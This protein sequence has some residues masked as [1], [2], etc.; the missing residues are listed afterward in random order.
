MNGAAQGAY[1][2][3]TITNATT[4][5]ATLSIDPAAT[6]GAR[7]VTVQTPGSA[8]QIITVNNG[9]TVQ[10]TVPTAP[11][12]VTVSP[13][14]NTAGVPINTSFTV[15]FSG[16]IN[17]STVAPTNAYLSPNQYGCSPTNAI[18]FTENVDAS[19]R[20]LTLTPSAVL[21]VG[22]SYYFCINYNSTPYIKDPSG[23]VVS[24]T[25]FLFT[26]GFATSN[27]GPTY[28]TGS[29]A[30]GDTGV[31][32]N[33]TPV[34]GFD[35]AF[36]P[37]T[38]LSG[39]NIYQGS[40]QV[41]GVWS[42][43]SL[44][45]E[46][47]FTPAG[48]FAA[49]TTYTI[50]LSAALTDPAG[51]PLVNP[52]TIS[53]T[54]GAGADNTAA[55]LVS[56]TPISNST[57]GENPVI[58]LVFSKA[59]NPLTMTQGQ[60]YLYHNVTGIAV[61]G[62]TVTAS[63]DRRT[64]TMTL[65]GPLDPN[66]QYYWYYGPAYDQAQN[67]VG[68]NSIAFYTGASVDTT[69]PT[70]TAV[71]PPNGF[72]GIAVNAPIEILLSETIDPTTVNTTSLTLNP[73]MAGTVALSSSGSA[74]TFT[75][76]ANLTANHSYTVNA[77]GFADQNG[78]LV[79]PFSSSFTTS[80][81]PSSDTAQ[82]TITM[83]PTAGATG[84]ATN[85]V[86]VFTFSKPFDPVTV[87]NGG[88]IRL[89]D[90]T[91]S[92]YI[93]GALTFNAS[94][95]SVTFTPSAALEPNHQYCG[96][97]G[98]PYNGYIYD[99]AGNT[100]NYV[101]SQC[102]TTAAG[103]DT[104]PPTV[105]TV[106][107]LN[108]AARIGPNNPVTVTFSKPMNPTTLTN[109]NVALYVG[110]NVY[111]RSFSTSFDNT[112]LTFNSGNLPYS[113][114]FTVVVT[115]N[116]TDLA[117]NH[118]AG[119]FISTFTTI[120]QPTTTVPTVT[121]TR[122]VSGATGVPANASITWFI[123]EPLKTSTVPGAVQVSQNGVLLTGSITYASNNQVVI[124]T[125]AANF[126]A[127][128][129]I[130]AFFTSA[131]TDTSGN[132]LTNYQFSFTVAQALTS[133]NP[134][135]LSTSP[136]QYSS[137]SFQNSII[138]VQFSKPLNPAMV[139]SA[140][141][142]VNNCNSTAITGSL[143]LLAG[144]TVV[145]F[146]PATPLPASC[147]YADVYATSSLQDTSSLPFA[148]TSWRFY[149]T[150][151]RDTA[152]P[153]VSTIAPTANSTA[154]GTN[155]TI[156]IQFSEALDQI[157]VNT[158]TLTLTGNSV[159]IPW[160]ATFD[161]TGT[162]LTITPQAS[163]PASTPITVAL[164]SGVNDLAGNALPA[165]S[166]VFTT[167]SAPDF[168]QP[169]VISS[170]VVNG[171]TGVPVTSVF[172]VTYSKPIDTRT[173]VSAGGVITLSD[174]QTGA[175]PPITLSFSSDGTQATIQ[176]QSLLGVNRSYSLYVCNVQDLDGNGMS[177]C[178]GISFTTALVAPTGGPA[179]T[180][181]L[182]PNGFRI[183]TNVKPQIQ[184]DRPVDLT[185]LSGVT[186]LQ[187]S[188]PVS[189][190]IA[191]SV[192]NT[193]L[194][195][196]PNALLV[197]N[198]P[199][200]LTI[201]GV[202][203]AAGNQ[204]SGTVT[205]NFTTGP[206]IDL[207]TPVVTALTPPSGAITGTN[208]V[209]RLTFDEPINP[210]ASN[211][212]WSLYNSVTNVQ[213]PG[214][215]ISASS[216]LLSESIVWPGTLDPNTQYCW[217]AYY[218]YD[219]AG[220]NTYTGGFCFTTSSRPVTSAPTV[221]S[222]TPPNGQA[223]VPI[224]ALIQ[225][226]LSSLIDATSVSTTSL[227]LSPSA[228]ATS[229]VSLAPSGQTITLS[230][231]TGTLTPNTSYTL[232]AAG[233]KDLNGNMVMP[234]S[235]TFTTS[236]VND[237][238][239]GTITLSSP[240]P[241]ATGV[242][243]TSA[244]T[245]TL[246]KVLD[247]N[248]VLPGAFLVYANNNSNQQIPGTISIGG[249]G[250]T[251]T[252]TPVGPMPPSTPISVYVGYNSSLY[253]LAGNT[254]ND[255]YNAGFTTASTADT[256]PPAILSVTP[257]NG[258][259]NVGPNAVV[260][261]IFSKALNYNTLNA[262]NFILYNG[263]TNLGAS[264]SRSADNRTV[265]LTATLPYSSTIN[266]AVNTTVQDLAGNFLASPFS[267]SFTVEPQPLTSTA[268]VTQMRPSNGA[269]GVLLNDTITLYFTSPLSAATVPAAFYVS[270]NGVLL[271]GSV[272]VS[273]DG[274]SAVWTG[275]GFSN[276][277][278]IQVFFT[279]AADTSGN[280]VSSYSAS[281]TAAVAA[282]T[283]T[284]LV[285]A[286]PSQYGSGN[287]LNS[288]VDLQFSHGI[289]PSS[290]NS[291]TFY[292][293][294][295]ASGSPIAGTITQYQNNAVL[296]FTPGAALQPNTYYYVYYTAGL[297]DVNGVALAAGN[298]YFYTGTATNGT[299]PAISSAAP[300]SGAS[301]VGDNATI[302]FSFNEPMDTLSISSAAGG[303]TVTLTSGSTPIPFSL[304]F[305]GSTYTTVTLTPYAPLPDNA[306]LVL[307]LMNGITDPA[308]H[309]ISTQS[310]SFHT[311]VGADFSAPY[312]AY[313]SIDSSTPAVPVNSTFTLI[314]NK[315][316]DRN[317]VNTSSYSYYGI[318]DYTVGLTV[319]TTVSVSADGQTVTYV[320]VANLAPSHSFG[321]W[322]QYATDLN[323]NAQTNFAVNFTTSAG[324]VTTPPAVITTNPPAGASGVPLNVL[325][326]AQFSEAVSGAS[327]SQISLTSGGSSVPF[328]ASLVFA[329][330]TV[331]LTPATLLMPNTTYTATIR[332]VQDVAGNTMAGTTALTFTTG[333]NVDNNP[334]PNVLSAVAGGLPLTNNINVNNV[335]D[336]PT[337]VI[338][339]DT[340]VEPAS[341]LSDGALIMYLNSN[342]NIT[343]PL[344]VAFSSD[345][346]TVTVT[347]PPGTLAAATEY[348]FRV[349]YNNRIRDWAGAS[350]GNQYYIYYFTTQ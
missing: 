173:E 25:Y 180:F 91:A 201:A 60:F 155:S 63:A 102:F 269:T 326:E 71:S 8:P 178:F 105:I 292:L 108:N 341:L 230:L 238:S 51:N 322:A 252:F 111:T 174:N 272:V 127:G 197:P 239:H 308:G 37:G 340:P 143:S 317:T 15:V 10:S 145:R 270:Q 319:P 12:I 99:I 241:G 101:Y 283:V 350:N 339:L 53:F 41:A 77:A 266:V 276:N 21:A 56:Y 256:T 156:R 226:N 166:S 245:V 228:P 97:G 344:N 268:T 109:T 11:T 175:A 95:T 13:A 114:T 9:F 85:S 59:I 18:P 38:Q 298:F 176:P 61:L 348:Q 336:N 57:T 141:F 313:S 65:P 40:M 261:L 311:G 170:S 294:L 42:Y 235:S 293:L 193:V 300:F 289:L 76:A 250:T 258:A 138:D 259:S 110:T 318:Y 345:Q 52:Q 163:L 164:S 343:Y 62:T 5:V 89:Y 264:V 295:Q 321:L 337:I 123:S 215:A 333:T 142:Y 209:I 240:A 32:T 227:T 132:P 83:A 93:S 80:S 1:G 55:T 299:T 221:T 200:T 285:S 157:S 70:V 278:Y 253:D 153:A 263:L 309:A 7:N 316:L 210:I 323:G 265:T 247:P 34:L 328:T 121:A 171:Q 307:G 347:L 303:S 29:V 296:R 332:G 98:Y 49:N 26:T 242:P 22:S 192:G 211:A 287:A 154:I 115:P 169:S 208:P 24:G 2:A 87:S 248:S 327:L 315:P 280:P 19:G 48:G 297:K 198:L 23:D 44:F 73:A 130:V 349:G 104:T 196:A 246:S 181:V 120:P 6:L 262:Q 219:L 149:Y 30:N 279:G 148:G 107:P 275:P 222:A 330:S 342:T 301:G 17:P 112:T 74:I 75:P 81:S 190:T 244:I 117:N 220:N 182:P 191:G 137:G 14:N 39:F 162:V 236:A 167:G 16:P 260:T 159:S 234:F 160:N 255:L 69:S 119:Q 64:F 139:N 225:V 185:S 161:S 183:A 314:F 291:S 46:A 217:S 218:I 125:P 147:T 135:I 257:A 136:G 54:T 50:Q 27:T 346:K 28:Q 66:T 202:K 3:V 35:K 152:T 325:I 45:T 128:A 78:N 165:F 306:T 214:A 88:N 122:P 96:Y 312:V 223:A 335:P 195:L 67:Y 31:G 274:R 267:S 331:R 338:T 334:T 282:S 118:L 90:G 146:T 103:A 158:G 271:S 43:N 133:V 134:A 126:L 205:R 20:I 284:T 281:F 131:A 207:V 224:D 203:D 329:D 243:I 212:G 72:T 82:G 151:S 187:G 233:F 33:V 213:V 232:N 86:V 100:F 229:G 172:T 324:A 144:N 124:F 277:A 113:T 288:V 206:S 249:G 273:G 177:P 168:G 186:L 189:F 204:M 310:I 237:T 4:A 79:T 320:P 199:F 286:S 140:N 58:R 188:T 92:A 194:T 216:D 251:L 254:F 94:F 84:V 47:T 302:R 184:F 116:V 305:S 106:M 129:G 179:V 36:N 231:G 68:Y 290:V 150:A 304:S